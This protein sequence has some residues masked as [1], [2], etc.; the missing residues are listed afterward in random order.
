MSCPFG[1]NVGMPNEQQSLFNTQPDPWE[2]DDQQSAPLAKVVF[3]EG[4]DEAYDYRIPASLGGQVVAGKRLHVPLGR[5]NRLRVAYCVEV[6]SGTLGTHRLKDVQAVLDDEPL[7]TPAMLRLTRWMAEYYLTSWGKVLE[8]VVPAGVRAAAG[9]RVQTVFAVPPHVAARSTRLNLPA[10]QASVLHA[11]LQ[12]GRPLTL[13]ELTQRAKCTEGPVRSLRQKGL[14]AAQQQRVE[15]AREGREVVEPH[16]PIEL[17]ATQRAALEGIVTALHGG[18]HETFLL[19]GVTGSGKTEVYIKA[20][21]AMIGFGRQA[22]VLVPEISLTPQT[23]R[24]FRSRFPAV[25]VL[26]S[27]LTDSERNWHWQRIARGEVSVVVGARSAV[28]RPRPNWA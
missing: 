13:R 20:I 2:L 7:L 12:A 8:G 3:A 15:S 16:E 25:A 14:V 28:L 4:V 17:N 6:H 24:R 27:H 21:E 19:H 11:L 26:H 10:K 22:I 23:Q 5:G 9:T 18:R 1:M